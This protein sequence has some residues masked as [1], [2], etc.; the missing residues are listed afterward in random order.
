MGRRGEETIILK[1][2]EIKIKRKTQIDTD[3]R[4]VLS[5]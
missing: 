1:E 4:D 5:M 3:K 2:K